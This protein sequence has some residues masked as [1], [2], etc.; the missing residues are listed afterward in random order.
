MLQVSSLQSHQQQLLTALQAAEKPLLEAQQ[1]L[2]DH[3]SRRK[4]LE[5]TLQRK[6]VALLEAK[7]DA[8]EQRRQAEQVPWVHVDVY[9][10]LYIAAG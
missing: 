3:D 9:L 7:R 6:T 1:A 8:K 2:E 4:Q 10:L 5:V